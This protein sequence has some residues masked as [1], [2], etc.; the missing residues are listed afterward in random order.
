MALQEGTSLH[1]NYVEFVD[2]LP[3]Q[4]LYMCDSIALFFTCSTQHIPNWRLF[5][6]H[7]SFTKA[8]DTDCDVTVTTFCLFHLCVWG[9][10]AAL[11]CAIRVGGKEHFEF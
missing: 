2:P 11:F 3:N 9:G 1:C 10:R 8:V 6:E 7:C 4:L 5:Y